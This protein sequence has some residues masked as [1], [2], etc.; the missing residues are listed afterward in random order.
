MKEVKSITVGRRERAMFRGRGRETV[1]EQLEGEE[2]GRTRR[3][4]RK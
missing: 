2:W 1:K 4:R 3:Q